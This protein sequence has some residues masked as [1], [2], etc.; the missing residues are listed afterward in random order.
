MFFSINR[1]HNKWFLFLYSKTSPIL[2]DEFGEHL[3]RDQRSYGFRSGDWDDHGRT[4]ILGSP[5]H[6]CVDF[7]VYFGSMSWWKIH[8]RPNI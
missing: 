5:T 2:P 6:F 3:T 1:A 7:D 8:P 4:F